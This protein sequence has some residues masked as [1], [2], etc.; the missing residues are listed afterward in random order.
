[1]LQRIDYISLEIGNE[2]AILNEIEESSKD[3]LTSVL[4]R[5]IFDKVMKG[6]L[7]L[8]KTTHTEVGLLMCDLDHFKTIND[9]Y[10]H[11]TG[12]AVL[13]HFSLLLNRHLRKSD[14]I[15]RFGG[16]EFII[17]LPATTEEDTY[18]LAKKLC[19]T[20][21]KT[22]FSSDGV[23]F[24]YTVSI[25]TLPIRIELSDPIYDDTI[26]HYLQ[27]VDKKLYMAKQQGRNC[28]V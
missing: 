11:L 20:T 25:G 18:T 23:A 10:G 14:Y 3:P 21:S 22:L 6:Q 8:A 15:F 5:R 1:M 17:I 27:E 7:A 12:D 28:V 26:N 16:E 4:T 2:I 24:N 13:Q 9:S 19:E